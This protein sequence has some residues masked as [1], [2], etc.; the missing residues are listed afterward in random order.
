M[1]IDTSSISASRRNLVVL[2]VGFILFSL[3]EATL[4]DGTGKTTLTILSGSITFNNPNVLSYFAWIMF[5]WFLLRFWQF[6]D[7]QK[8]W[9][10]FT[11]AMYKSDLMG[12]WFKENNLTGLNSYNGDGF[13]P[14]FGD[15]EWPAVANEKFIISKREIFKKLRIFSYIAIKTEYFGQYYFPYC[16]AG[17]AILVTLFV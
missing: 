6:S 3:G 5:I 13:Q 10:N 15:W 12:R 2:S 8:D 9:V 14:V 4:G 1:D 17:I 16:L 11:T 7:H